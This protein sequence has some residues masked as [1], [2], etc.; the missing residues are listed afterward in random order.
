MVRPGLTERIH[1]RQ[2][3]DDIA[4]RCGNTR[5]LACDVV[6]W[7]RTPQEQRTISPVSK[8]KI[9]DYVKL[10][11]LPDNELH[12]RA[13]FPNEPALAAPTTSH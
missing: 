6:R 4:K 12:L 10:T 11:L 9:G 1:G 7:I 2:K 5:G 3:L 8:M 13:L